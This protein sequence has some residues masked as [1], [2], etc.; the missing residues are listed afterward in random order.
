M[1]SRDLHIFLGNLLGVNVCYGINLIDNH[2]ALITIQIFGL[3]EI[4]VN[5]FDVLKATQLNAT[6]NLNDGQS[7]ILKFLLGEL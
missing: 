6:R 7:I 2:E 4:I 3:S 1:P 5:Y